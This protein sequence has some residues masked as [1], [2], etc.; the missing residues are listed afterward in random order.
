[1]TLGARQERTAVG[2]PLALLD[3]LAPETWISR[4][5]GPWAWWAGLGDGS[6]AADLAR[7][8][9]AAIAGWEV[10]RHALVHLTHLLDEAGIEGAF[11]KG[12]DLNL[13]CYP[14]PGLRP[15]A[16][17]D[18]LVRVEDLPR[19]AR[20]LAVAGYVRRDRPEDPPANTAFEHDFH[21][22][23]LGIDLDVHTAVDWPEVLGVDTA[24]L[25]TR[26]ERHGET[27]IPL[28]PLPDLLLNVA[29]HALRDFREASSRA[30][31]DA[32]YVLER[33]GRPWEAVVDRARV[34]RTRPALRLLLLRMHRY[35]D[36]P[37]P[38]AALRELE[39]GILPKR[40]G[41]WLAS[42]VDGPA[43]LDRDWLERAARLGMI[44]SARSRARLAWR[45]ARLRLGGSA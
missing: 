9:R 6:V 20:L 34:W 27:G 29:T 8:G 13:R 2:A 5:L 40:I 41:N 7:D 11:L 36:E 10:Q 14:E 12:A 4:G 32:H 24:G 16:D 15:M 38:D 37:V 25:L 45:Y 18:L 30:L 23:S 17:L 22:P 33:M 31:V 28:L 42:S 1:M 43:A 3:R 21:D 35:A 26:R 39:V 44:E 19:L